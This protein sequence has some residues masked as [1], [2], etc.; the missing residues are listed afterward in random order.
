VI[1][2]S[3]DEN[4]PTVVVPNSSGNALTTAV[5][6]Y[7]INAHKLVAKVVFPQNSCLK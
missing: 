4:A 2:Q 7:S 3:G 6:F 5:Q 1:V